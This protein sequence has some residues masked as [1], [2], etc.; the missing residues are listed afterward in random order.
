MSTASRIVVVGSYNTDL[1]ARTPRMPQPGETILGGPFHVGPGGKG[2]NQAVAAARLG[3][4]VQLVA[5][6]GEDSFGD[7][8]LQNLVREGIDTSYVLRTGR[9]HTGAALIF[10][11]AQGENMIVVA[12]GAN[13][14]LSPE[15][16]E[17]ALDAIRAADVLLVQLEVPMPTVERACLLAREAGVRVL[18]NPAPGRALDA[19]LLQTVDV[20]IPNETEAAIISGI[21]VSDRASAEAAGRELLQRGVGA[22]VMTLGAEGALVVTDGGVTHVPAR[23]VKAVDTTGAGDAFCGALAVGLAEGQSLHTAV[24]FA[25]AAAAVKVTRLGTAPAMP[26]R[27]EVEAL[28]AG[29]PR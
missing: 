3:A 15:H 10:V 18:L 24:A 12:P 25:G 7:Q 1:M 26:R 2:A 13:D 11:D 29:G 9:T 28:L 5:S 16:V 6:L 17:G 4:A 19:G 20:L 22:V 14:L 8:A 23:P 21:P 27:P